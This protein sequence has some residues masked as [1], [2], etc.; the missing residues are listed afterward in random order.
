M[1]GGNDWAVYYEA[2]GSLAGFYR[3]IFILFIIFTLFALV[4][5]VTGIFVESAMQTSNQDQE[6]IVNEGM[7]E[8]KL[9]FEA[10]ERVFSELDGDDKGVITLEEFETSLH[11]ER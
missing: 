6:V 11:E 9:Y 2:L 3:F 8:K 1:S 5:I 4:N 7:E 10:L